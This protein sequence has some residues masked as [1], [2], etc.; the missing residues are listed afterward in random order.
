MDDLY[1]QHR[2]GGPTVRLSPWDPANVLNNMNS[3]RSR[4]SQVRN[5]ISAVA[6]AAITSCDQSSDPA[7]SPGGGSAPENLILSQTREVAAGA[8]WDR[9]FNGSRPGTLKITVTGAAPFTVTLVDDSVYKLM[10]REN[11]SARDFESGVFLNSTSDGESF[12][13]TC[14]LD[15]GKYWISISNNTANTATY[16]IECH[17]W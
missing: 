9:E 10:V 16:K 5:L 2:N 14:R 15:K 8:I 11:M 1:V 6:I 17:S 4:L 3:T 13:T 12:Q 7:K